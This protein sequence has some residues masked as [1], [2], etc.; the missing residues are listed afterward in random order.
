ME[1]KLRAEEARQH[2]S[3]VTNTSEDVQETLSSLRT[4][5]DDLG[6]SFG[7]R[8]KDAFDDKLTEWKDSS[9]KLMEALTGLGTFLTSAADTIEEVDAKL[10]EGLNG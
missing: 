1:I 4:R 8:T 10:A 2:A 5:L 6:D 7:G 9:D 3:D